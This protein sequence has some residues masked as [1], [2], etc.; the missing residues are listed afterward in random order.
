MTA[1]E[2]FAEKSDSLLHRGRRPYMTHSVISQPPI[3]ALRKVRS[4]NR[5]VENRLNFPD[6]S[7]LM[8]AALTTLAH[9]SVSS[10]MTWRS[11]RAKST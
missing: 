5:V 8:F 9:F 7:G 2:R 4:R 10:A 6:H 3:T 11:R 1:P